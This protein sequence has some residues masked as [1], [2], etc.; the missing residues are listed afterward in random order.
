MLLI[1]NEVILLQH[2][3]LFAFLVSQHKWHTDC[4]R[5]GVTLS[6]PVVYN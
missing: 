6:Y 1:L 4:F 3:D 2:V 5:Y